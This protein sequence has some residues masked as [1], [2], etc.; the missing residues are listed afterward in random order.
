MRPKNL[1]CQTA[2]TSST[3][4]GVVQEEW[5]DGEG[6]GIV[7]FHGEPAMVRAFF[8]TLEQEEGRSLT[9][10]AGETARGEVIEEKPKVEALK[11]QKKI[12]RQSAAGEG[13]WVRRV[14]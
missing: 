6:A 9:V 11:W 10:L 7:H 8:E 1:R 12:L 5:P 4:K 13:R 3:L 2:T 14:K